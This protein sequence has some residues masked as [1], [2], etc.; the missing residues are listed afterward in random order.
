MTPPASPPALPPARR[1]PAARGAAGAGAAPEGEAPDPRVEALRGLPP[2]ARLRLAPDLDALL[3]TAADVGLSGVLE[4]PAHLFLETCRLPDR[5][6]VR[7]DQWL[8][9]QPPASLGALVG[10]PARAG[11]RRALGPPGLV[12]LTAAL[13][14]FLVEE[15]SVG[16]AEG[17]SGA[18]A[19]AGAPTLPLE[20][21]PGELA[22]W[23]RATGCGPLLQLPLGAAL[24]GLGFGGAPLPLGPLRVEDGLLCPVGPAGSHGGAGWRLPVPARKALL[25]ALAEAAALWPRRLTEAEARAALAG[26][27]GPGLRAVLRQVD[28]E[29]GAL[30]AALPPPA[31]MGSSGAGLRWDAAARALRLPVDPGP[32]IERCP[33]APAA[34]PSAGGAAGVVVVGVDPRGGL[35]LRCGCEGPC[36]W[37]LRVLEALRATLCA[38]D[39]DGAALA[40]LDRA[41]APAAGGI[42]ALDA[43]LARSGGDAPALSLRA[44]EALGWLV[45]RDE[46]RVVTAAP[47]LVR[48]AEGGWVWRRPPS[49][50]PA[51]LGALSGQP[52]DRRALEATLGVDP[53][54]LP[55]P[56]RRLA[57][58]RQLAALADHPRVFRLDERGRAL[59]RLPIRAVSLNLLLRADSEGGAELVAELD[60]A[61]APLEQLAERLR[62]MRGEG[63][64]I[65]FEDGALHVVSVED[66]A[67]DLVASLGARGLRF[68]ADGVDA[69][70]D[71]LDALDA[72]LPVR[73]DAELRGEEHEPGTCP[74]VIL[75]LTHD[76][77][78]MLALRLRVRVVALPDARPRAPGLGPP[79]AHGRG[80]DGA[81]VWAARDRAGEL[82]AAHDLLRRLGLALEA[83]VE[84]WAW[85]VARTDEALQLIEQLEVEVRSRPGALEVVWDGAQPGP[86]REAGAEGLTVQV[87]GGRDWFG[88]R[89]G[90]DVDGVLI[91]LEAL[92]E[93]IAQGRRYLAV[94]GGGWV[95]LSAPLRA[96]LLELERL[97]RLGPE[98]RAL[99]PVA[100]GL[101]E[102]LARHGVVV[103]ADARW[104]ALRARVHAAGAADLQAPAALAATLRPYQLAGL[105]W[106]AQL[107]GW[108]A[109]AVLADDMGLGKTVQALALLLHRAA[110]GPALVVAPTSV[111][112][113]WRAE[114][115]RFA[116]GL[117]VW[118]HRGRRSL[119]P[120]PG[121]GALVIVSYGL[122][123]ADREAFAAV[124][125]ATVVLDEAH[126]IKNPDTARARAAQAL[127]AGF[128]L[129]LTGTP[130]ENRVQELWSLLHVTAPGLLGPRARFRE[131]FVLPIEREGDRESRARLAALI[132]PFVLRR[133]KAE[134]APELPARTERTELLPL[135]PAHAAR[136]AA[137]RAEAIRSLAE[138]PE[139][140]EDQRRL[141][142]LAALTRLRLL[143]CHPA[144]VDGPAAASAPSAKLERVRALV[145]EL[146]ESGQQVLLFSQFV[147]HLDLVG[148]ALGRDGVRLCRLDGS[149]PARRRDEEVARFQAG[150]ADAFLI[151]LQAG[152]AGLNLTA[153]SAVIHLDPWWNP[154]VEDQAT[155]RAHRIGQQRP[156]T[157]VR[158]LSEGTV[159]QT[160]LEMHADKR[161]LVSGLLAGSE[162]AARLD[163]SAL[164][165]LVLESAALALGDAD[166]DELDAGEGPD[167]GAVASTGA[168]AGAL[169]AGVRR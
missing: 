89:G 142:V 32:P 164:S 68:P 124:P 55:P 77:D 141:A 31:L 29:I 121:P 166:P 85:F 110:I 18:A 5:I 95:R 149:T 134:V 15:H 123:V 4:A 8:A 133:R 48:P 148:E 88:L 78:G 73:V 153:A 155:G 67:V 13:R 81:R 122:L 80:A 47:L 151:S 147:R 167:V 105:R 76:S 97:S 99:P 106:M 162:A 61:P 135:G 103:E 169:V 16:A 127:Q 120:P 158:L 94:E 111:E 34:A 36:P 126:A 14:A 159:E 49:V 17:G 79:F 145:S 7:L 125:W 129:A 86:L 56:A 92:L 26:P 27:A 98:G 161:E 69:L 74:R 35:A 60:G 100:V 116:P 45:V 30:R 72:I 96:Q 107:A 39:A 139:T 137:A 10:A 12:E 117:E 71:R 144:L 53:A 118:V 160:V 143:A 154:A 93:L 165:A 42:D 102:E 136:Y 23:A 46:A 40:A 25:S 114:A 58:L 104:A 128:V 87:G 157:V 38:P 115:A 22:A 24:H 75:K 70:F 43:V 44:G 130:V 83:A 52:G 50:D 152:G 11:L 6:A 113:N 1:R 33:Q 63:V 66:A 108:G 91:E 101:V 112:G 9:E 138:L 41:A 168:Q 64:S 146:R 19:G 54:T 57:G 37:R 59:L 51:A 119:A 65:L 140:A 21:A 131:D 3:A 156:V 109:G 132:R 62:A 163:L 90:L 20:P 2:A 84:P 28:D 150:L 82:A